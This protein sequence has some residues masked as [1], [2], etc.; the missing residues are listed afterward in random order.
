MSQN[1]KDLSGKELGQWAVTD[2]YEVRTKKY[3]QRPN[4]Q[5][6]TYWLC[7][8][9]CGNKVY[10]IGAHLTNGTSTKC[11]LCGTK[12][13]TEFGHATKH[14]VL[15]GYKSDARGRNYCWSI[16]D[17]E[18][19]SLC[20]APCLYC[21]DLPRNISKSIYGTG[22][23]IYNGIDRTN[24]SLGYT[25]ENTVSCCRICNRAKSNLSYEDWIS[26]LSRVAMRQKGL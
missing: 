21:G 14:T 22:D 2:T 23:F 26:Y 9:S 5:R 1:F 16:T 24:N 4:G 19:F 6:V 10:V 3:G 13:R 12:D 25:K 20:K 8:C 18:F 15:C 7:K 17:D 11:R